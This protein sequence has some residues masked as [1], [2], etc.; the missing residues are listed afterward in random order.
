MVGGAA[1]SVPANE[2]SARQNRSAI[3][4]KHAQASTIA[5][6]TDMGERFRTSMQ[7]TPDNR[8]TARLQFRFQ[9]RH[10]ENPRGE[11]QQ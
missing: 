6:Q 9:D 4:R 3:T 7:Y 11:G 1:S 5:P 2:G 8:G 10:T